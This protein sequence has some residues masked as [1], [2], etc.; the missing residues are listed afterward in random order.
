MVAAAASFGFVIAVAASQGFV[1]AVAASLGFVVVLLV[2]LFFL[3]MSGCGISLTLPVIGRLIY[4]RPTGRR[5]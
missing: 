3:I 1:V 4:L 2:L 5:F